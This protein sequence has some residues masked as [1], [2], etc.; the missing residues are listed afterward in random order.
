H[1]VVALQSWQAVV[2]AGQAE[3]ER[4]YYREYLTSEKFRGFDEALVRLMDL[5]EF[6]GVGKVV[7]GTLY[8]L[9]TPYRLVKGWLGKALTRPEAP[10]RPE[11]PILAEALGG[12]VD[13]LRREA[14]RRS[15]EHPLW[16]HV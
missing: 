2:Q 7:S 14:A 12:W 10:G 15:G 13:L 5:L 4:R 6:P 9:R 16:A 1:D 8:V 11:L 3:F